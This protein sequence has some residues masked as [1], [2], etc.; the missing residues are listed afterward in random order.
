MDHIS[1]A[2][3]SFQCLLSQVKAISTNNSEERPKPLFFLFIFLEEKPPL[4]R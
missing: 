2:V 3:R 4:V 1:P